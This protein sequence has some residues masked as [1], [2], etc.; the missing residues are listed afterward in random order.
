MTG[1]GICGNYQRT[2]GVSTV[3]LIWDEPT[4]VQQERLN[5]WGKEVR[6]MKGEPTA[7]GHGEG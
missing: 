1:E 4:P 6:K 7:D 5:S 3:S 2:N